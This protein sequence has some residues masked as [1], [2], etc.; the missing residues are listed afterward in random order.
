[1]KSKLRAVGSIVLL[2]AFTFTILS[3]DKLKNIGKKQDEAPAVPA[4]A[5]VSELPNYKDITVADVVIT[6]LGLGQGP[7]VESQST[8]EVQY[9]GWVYDPAKPENKGAKFYE[10]TEKEKFTLG[11]AAL[12]P[13]IEKGL[14]GMKAGGKRRL[15][16][17]AELGYGAAG[18][19]N[20]PAGA[21]LMVEISVLELD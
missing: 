10:S 17:P 6:D 13:G 15:I 5:T 19:D 18:H 21:I 20:V 11:K 1:M 4:Q 3:C 7:A 9:S 8:V 14:V 16:I 2:L 12:L